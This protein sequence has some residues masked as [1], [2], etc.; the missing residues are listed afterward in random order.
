MFTKLATLTATAAACIGIAAVPA[1]AHVPQRPAGSFPRLVCQHVPGL[2]R[3]ICVVKRPG[4]RVYF[5]G[6]HH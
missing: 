1:S 5:P 6:L 3:T 2:H 4:K